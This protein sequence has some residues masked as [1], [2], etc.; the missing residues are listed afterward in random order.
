MHRSAEEA[1]A[2]YKSIDAGNSTA[3]VKPASEPDKQEADSL[4]AAAGLDPY[5]NAEIV[6]QNF[7]W[8]MGN[9]QAD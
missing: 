1:R 8:R 9:R 4:A 5:I 3:V 6:E 7:W 2:A